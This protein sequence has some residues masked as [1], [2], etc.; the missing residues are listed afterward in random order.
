MK[1]ELVNEL[2]VKN[3]K[4]IFFASF[5]ETVS[6]PST[7]Q[8]QQR[9]KSFQWVGKT[10]FLTNTVAWLPSNSNYDVE[11]IPSNRIEASHDSNICIAIKNFIDFSRSFLLNSVVT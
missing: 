4:K 7:Y 9:M 1:F 10:F 2:Y 5:T 3:K 8:L 6:T 11:R